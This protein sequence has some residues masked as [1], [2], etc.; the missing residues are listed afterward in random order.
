MSSREERILDGLNK[1]FGFLGCHG[2]TIEIEDEWKFSCA[3]NDLGGGD[4]EAE[5]SSIDDEE[6]IVQVDPFFRINIIFDESRKKVV[7]AKPIEY[8]SQGWMG[9]LY[10]DRYGNFRGFSGET[11][12]EEDELEERL[13]NYIDNV[14]NTLPYLTNPVRVERFEEDSDKTYLN[15]DPDEKKAKLEAMERMRL[16]GID[17]KD[18]EKFGRGIY[19]FVYVDHEK[20]RYRKT[21]T[22]QD[23][24]E[25]IKNLNFAFWSCKKTW[26]LVMRV[27][28]MFC[29]G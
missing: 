8:V 7:A 29:F 13:E 4:Y 22:S 9:T 6:D 27:A 17:T 15:T 20:K 3:V 21:E 24:M 19:T 16:L 12:C 1:I 28:S 5:I 11:G 2:G 25:F 10:I 18:V 26:L 14:T 23:D